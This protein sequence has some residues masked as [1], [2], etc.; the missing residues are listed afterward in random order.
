MLLL[1]AIVKFNA[2]LDQHKCRRH[3]RQAL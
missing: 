1:I 2:P 3:L